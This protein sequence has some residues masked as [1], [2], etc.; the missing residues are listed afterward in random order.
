MTMINLYCRDAKDTEDDT[1][2]TVAVTAL[3]VFTLIISD[4]VCLTFHYKLDTWC[5]NE[6]APFSE[7]MLI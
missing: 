2:D 7:R 1:V 5:L 4:F 6:K 3:E